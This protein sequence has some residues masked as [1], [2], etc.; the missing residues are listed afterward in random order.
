MIAVIEA[1]GLLALRAL[2]RQQRPRSRVE[3]VGLA[4]GMGIGLISLGTFYLVYAHIR[5]DDLTIGVFL[6]GLLLG[7]IG[8][9]WMVARRRG[10]REASRIEQRTT[11]NSLEASMLILIFAS[12][13]LVCLDALSQPLLSFDARAIWGMKAKVIF[14][15]E[16][17]YGEDFLNPDRLHAKQRY[18][19]AVPLA[20]SFVYHVMGEA[21]DRMG[22]I[23]FPL[24]FLALLLVFYAE[25]RKRFRRGYALFGT[26]LLSTL[27]AFTIYANGGAASGYSDV[28]LTYFYTVLALS[29]FR[30]F[31]EKRS[32]DLALAGIFGVFALFT[33]NEGL[34]LWGITL[35]CFTVASGCSGGS[36]TKKLRPL[37]LL[38]A[39]SVTLMLPWWHY[40]S[41]LPLNEEDFIRLLTPANLIAGMDRF[42]YILK[43]FA[44]EFILRPQL[45]SVLAP[46]LMLAFCASPG[47]AI[48]RPHSVLLW[49]GS[50]YCVLLVMIYLVIP[51]QLEELIPVSLTRLLMPLTPTLI[52]WMLIQMK[53]TS[54]LPER[55]IQRESS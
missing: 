21:D 40:R 42:P 27:P 52:L 50:L 24:F 9:N 12:C 46:C 14:S 3:A 38:A 20:Q 29:L 54:L 25:L 11:V 39:A 30:W 23:L 34:A 1:I 31:R 33:K 35:V 4:F 15:Q 44:R 48:R 51:W 22:K 2:V 16:Q 37:F 7:L 49:I 53:E 17:I 32:T 43:S 47:R 19:L 55:W 45:W 6:I 28:P 18:P 8:L 10:P 26:A 13:F 5:L 41:Q 36:C